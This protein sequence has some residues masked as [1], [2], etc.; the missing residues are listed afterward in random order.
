MPDGAKVDAE[1]PDATPKT[2]NAAASLWNRMGGEEKIRSLCNDLYTMHS[3]DPLT[4]AW[5]GGKPGSAPGTGLDKEG[6]RR[7]ADEVRENVLGF[8]SAGIGGPLEYKGND[9]KT[10]RSRFG[11]AWVG[12]PA[13]VHCAMSCT[14]CTPPTR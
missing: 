6:N 9:R 3:S 12:R 14:R 10:A 4:A 1:V 11:I 2:A 7:T 5:F 13:S 8:F